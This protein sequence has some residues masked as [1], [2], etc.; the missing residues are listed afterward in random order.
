[1]LPLFASIVGFLE[2]ALSV[3]LRLLMYRFAQTILTGRCMQFVVSN[4]SPTLCAEFM[5]NT[6]IMPQLFHHKQV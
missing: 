6:H 4:L 5:P 1:M 2:S 3:A